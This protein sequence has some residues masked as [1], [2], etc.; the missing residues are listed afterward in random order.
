MHICSP[1][2]NAQPCAQIENILGAGTDA[3]Q[4]ADLLGPEYDAELQAAL[5]LSLSQLTTTDS[6]HQPAQ[7]EQVHFK[8]SVTS[9]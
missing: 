4:Q 6:K 3:Q 2:P 9:G 5:N 8:S 1:L 7:P